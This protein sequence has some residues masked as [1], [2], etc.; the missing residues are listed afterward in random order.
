MCRACH[1]HKREKCQC[2]V[3]FCLSVSLPGPRPRMPQMPLR[4]YILE[5]MIF[6]ACLFSSLRSVY[7][8]S[9][10]SIRLLGQGACLALGRP[11]VPLV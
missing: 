7:P 3:G 9:A 8:V 5:C 1:L 11:V 2:S 6:A 10:P 4:L